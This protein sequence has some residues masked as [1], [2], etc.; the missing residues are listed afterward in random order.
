MR[1]VCGEQRFIHSVKPC[2]I[3]P[4]WSK[5]LGV[6]IVAGLLGA[7]LVY[8]LAGSDRASLESVAGSLA[9]GLRHARNR[10]LNENRPAALLLDFV[11]REFRVAGGQYLRTLPGQIHIEL[12]TARSGRKSS[13]GGT[14]RFFPD[15][16]STG[17]RIT[18]TRDGARYL[19][20]TDWLTGKVSVMASVVGRARAR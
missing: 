1:A 2:T 16:S 17:G 7:F 5:L 20:N 10:A 4:T 9:H 14:I 6:L 3:V 18:L 11:K 15:G 12:Y 8:P 13:E 19:V